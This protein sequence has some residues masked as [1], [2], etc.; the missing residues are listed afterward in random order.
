M[1]GIFKSG[2]I[3][4]SVFFLIACEQDDLSLTTNP[5]LKSQDGPALITAHR[6]GENLFPENT[7]IAFQGSL[8]LGVDVLEVD[9]CLTADGKLVANHD[10]T[11]NRTSDGEGGII[12][13]SFDELQQFNFGYWFQASD[14]SYPYR[15]DPV[16]IPGLDQIFTQFPNTRMIIEIKTPGYHGKIAAEALYELVNRYGMKEF[17]SVFSFDQQTMNHFDRLNATGIYT[18]ASIPD[19]IAF[20]FAIQDRTLGQLQTDYQVLSVPTDLEGIPIATTNSEFIEAAHSKG[21]AV[22]YWTI[23]DKEAMKQL[24]QIGADG[25]ITDSPDMM[26]EALEELGY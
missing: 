16:R 1:A 22:H 8:D 3:V 20:L 5:F 25:I 23:N 11:I 15:N 24:I 2:L 21:I 9:V 19:V 12:E 4:L 18:G 17:I 14:G 7:L 10:L 13:Y 6:G 26:Q